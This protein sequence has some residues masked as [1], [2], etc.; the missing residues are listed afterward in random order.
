MSTFMQKLSYAC[1]SLFVARRLLAPAS[2][3]LKVLEELM[4]LVAYVPSFARRRQY[5]FLHGELFVKVAHVLRVT[6]HIHTHKTKFTVKPL[7]FVCPSF[8]KF[9]DLADFAKITDCEYIF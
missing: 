3:E 6:L 4:L 1:I 7:L 2:D 9:R 8:R 5:R